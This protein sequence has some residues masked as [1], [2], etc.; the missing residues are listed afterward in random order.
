M[1]TLVIPQR[2]LDRIFD[3]ADVGAHDECWPWLKS[4]GSHGR[5]Q[6]GW[7]ENGRSVVT[8]ARR[9]AW[10]RIF[11]PI[12]DGLTVFNECRNSICINPSDLDLRTLHDSVRDNRQSLKACCP[13]GHPYD[14]R[15]LR[16]THQGDRRCV[17]CEIASNND[18]EKY[19]R[20]A[21]LREFYR[22]FRPALKES[23]DRQERIL[24]DARA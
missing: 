18:R 12:P 13:Q 4:S 11:G 1:T 19:R 2:V 16:I 3:G 9:V 20:Q 5:A 24:T 14:G 21:A 22:S 23:L 15:N 17:I 10:T 6:V 8:L 7:Y